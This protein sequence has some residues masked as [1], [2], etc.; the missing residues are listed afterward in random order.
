MRQNVE[1]LELLKI[2]KLDWCIHD[3]QKILKVPCIFLKS[4]NLFHIFCGVKD[5]TV[6][7]ILYRIEKDCSKS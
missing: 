1:D 4:K 2:R 5:Q 3:N 6:E 7:P